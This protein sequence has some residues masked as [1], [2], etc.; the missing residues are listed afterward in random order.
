LVTALA[1]LWGI[2]RRGAAKT[3][4]AS[5][6]NM[7]QLATPVIDQ[8][9]HQF[10]IAAAFWNE[11]LTD[12]LD[13]A[14]CGRPSNF[15][16]ETVLSVQTT[17]HILKQA[18]TAIGYHSA[19]SWSPDLTD[20]GS[21]RGQPVL[22][23][24]RFRW[25]GKQQTF[26]LDELIEFR[27]WHI[28]VGPFGWVYLGTHDPYRTA[29]PGP[30]PRAGQRVDPAVILADDPQAAMQFRGIQHAS[31]AL[32][33]FPLCFDNWIYP[34]IRYHRNSA[35]LSMRV[36]NSNGKIPA[37]L[38]VRRVSE[39]RYLRATARYWHDPQFAVYVKRQLPAAVKIDAARRDLWKLI[40]VTHAPWTNW[41]VEKCVAQLQYQYARLQAAWVAWDVGHAHF[42]AADNLSAAQVAAQA[43][44]FLSHLQ[45]VR[46]ADHQLWLAT[47]A[48]DHVHQLQ[49][50]KQQSN[51]AAAGKWRAKELAARSQALLDSNKQN[52]LFWGKKKRGLKP[53]DPRKIWIRDVNAQYALA[54]ARKAMG[55]SGLAY[56]AAMQAGHAAMAQRRYLA[57]ILNVSLAKELV[58]LVNV[59]F[60][61]TNDQGFASA[62]KIQTLKTQR[63]AIKKR[64]AE[65][66]AQLASVRSGAKAVGGEP[67]V[68]GQHA[69]IH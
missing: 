61:I 40:D 28:S 68:T 17:R 39:V 38:I 18:F 59:D 6:G 23:L 65:I 29:A 13:V 25:H 43:K 31:Q 19:T 11:H 52:L 27:A 30:R 9:Q 26:P 51:S 5:A 55:Q 4:P 14:L 54:Q 41:R 69:P 15:L 62:A 44:E 7:V 58:A 67:G 21:I 3:A 16:H 35:V 32:L 53:T 37:T 22:I 63:A 20:F 24:V 48:F 50:L 60:H 33:D 34:N 8:H 47:L 49:K 66:D 36:F 57:A 64:I 56:A 12:W 10:S 45:Q 42:R 1:L 2:S 46:A